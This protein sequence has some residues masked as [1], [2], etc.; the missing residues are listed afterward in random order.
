MLDVQT[1]LFKQEPDDYAPKEL[2]FATRVLSGL[3]LSVGVCV[4]LLWD[5]GLVSF[6]QEELL[7]RQFSSMCL[8]APSPPAAVLMDKVESQNTGEDDEAAL[9]SS[10]S[11]GNGNKNKSPAP[12]AMEEETK[13]E[14]RVSFVRPHT[15]EHME[16]CVQSVR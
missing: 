1:R 10:A 16:D 5:M 9:T 6:A 14:T 15:Y 4:C 2:R 11:G 3:E 13:S 8:E 7:Q 12:A